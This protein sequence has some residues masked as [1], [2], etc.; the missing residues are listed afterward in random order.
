MRVNE[1]Q[2][3][4]GGGEGGGEGEQGGE[5][6]GGTGGGEGGLMVPSPGCR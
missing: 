1:G 3:D 4:S 2:T 6:G 5:G